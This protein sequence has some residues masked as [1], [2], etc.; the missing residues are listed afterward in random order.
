[1]P[2]FNRITLQ[3][4][5][6]VEIEYTL[7]GI[8]SRA[9]AVML[10]Y[11]IWWLLLTLA[12]LV[13]TFFRVAIVDFVTAIAGDTETIELWLSAIFLLIFFCLYVGYFVFFETVWQGQSP[14]KRYA[15]IRV[16][17]EDGKPVGLVQ[18]TLRSLLRPVDDFCFI[19]AF[20]I[21]LTRREKRLGDWVAGTVVV[22][23]QQSD[24]AALQLSDRAQAIAEDLQQQTDLSEVLPDDFATVRAYLQRRPTLTNTA[25][26]TVARSLAEPLLDK[27]DLDDIPQGETAQVF[28]EAVYL[29]YQQRSRR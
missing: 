22:Q 10:D 2:L 28:L 21:A 5:E 13:A 4:P 12:S 1:M 7:A 14:G 24:R 18:A 16:I 9:L 29:A 20:A 6:S 25:K 3:T 23:E 11:T 19:G 27:L 15:K 26:L 17:C 8:G